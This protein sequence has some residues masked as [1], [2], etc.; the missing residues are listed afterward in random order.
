MFERNFIDA[1]RAGTASLDD[2]GSFIEHWHC[3]V[4]GIELHEFLGMTEREHALWLRT[5]K[6]SVFLDIIG[7]PAEQGEKARARSM[8]G[9]TAQESRAVPA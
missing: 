8:A 4:S 2:L 9:K 3:H 6:N 1:C 5:G 7:H